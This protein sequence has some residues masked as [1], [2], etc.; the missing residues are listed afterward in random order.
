MAYT[1]AKGYYTLERPAAGS[2]NVRVS[3]PV[4]PS[5]F[6]RRIGLW[7]RAPGKVNITLNT[8]FDAVQLPQLSATRRRG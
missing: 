8:L 6:A 5:D 4:L 7:P 3:A 1:D 2:Y